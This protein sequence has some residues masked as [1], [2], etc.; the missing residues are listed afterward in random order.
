MDDTLHWFHG[1]S[2]WHPANS[3]PFPN[4]K[5]ENSLKS[6]KIDDDMEIARLQQLLRSWQLCVVN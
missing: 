5:S 6:G 4:C 2:Q 1:A 3:A